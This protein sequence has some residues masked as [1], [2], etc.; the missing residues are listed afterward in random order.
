MS[1]TALPVAPYTAAE[2]LRDLAAR[3]IVARVVAG[4]LELR[5]VGLTAA[6]REE[7]RLVADTFGA[8]LLMEVNQWAP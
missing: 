7:A 5:G 8:E 2:F 3:G 1:C 6:Q 4:K